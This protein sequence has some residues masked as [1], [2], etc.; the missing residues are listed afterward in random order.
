MT[1]SNTC[2]NKICTV[3]HSE[4]IK[5][6]KYADLNA[7]TSLKLVKHCT[8]EFIFEA[9]NYSRRGCRCRVDVCEV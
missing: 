3:N 7:V 4:S 9:S 2:D 1:Q 5:Y 6:F 8:D